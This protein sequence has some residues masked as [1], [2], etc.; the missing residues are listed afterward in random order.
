MTS[1]EYEALL[2]EDLPH[3]VVAE[4]AGVTES[5]VRRD[6]KKL[7]RGETVALDY[8]PTPVHDRVRILTLDIESRP[9]LSYHWGLWD[10]NIGIGQIVEHGG[11][12]CFAAK[13]LGDKNKVFRSTF[14]DG[15]QKMLEDLYALLSEADI[16]IGY[17]SD[18]YDI[19]RINNEFLLAG[20]PPPKPYKSIDL[21]KT[22]KGRF[23]LPSRKLD[24]L[25]QQTGVGSKVKHQGFDL[26]IGCMND[27]PE[28]WAVMKKYNLG[29][30]DVTEGA[31]LKLQPWLTNIPHL[32]MFTGDAFCCP[33]CGSTSLTAD[34][35]THTNVQTYEL[36]NCDDC[37]GWARGTATLGTTIRTRPIR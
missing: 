7:A 11:M 5:K 20:F 23:D 8:S 2:R 27:D 25:V 26:W 35:F 3:T 16:V 33:Y 9:L 18:R 21:I 29:D 22:N 12:M 31:Y 34:G 4:T 19:K 13:W 14:H 6:R 1:S 37:G 15:K 10:Q 17:N 32:G 30:V 36:Y 24:Y 28:A